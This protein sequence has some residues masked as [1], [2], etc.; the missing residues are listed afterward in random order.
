MRTS[1][2]RRL[3]FASF[4][5]SIFMYYTFNNYYECS[6]SRAIAKQKIIFVSLIDIALSILKYFFNS[7]MPTNQQ[8]YYDCNF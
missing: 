4:I 8:S 2:L 3:I 5:N 6:N 7:T 1:N